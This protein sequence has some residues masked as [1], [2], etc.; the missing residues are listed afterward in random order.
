MLNITVY[1]THSLVSDELTLKGKNVVVIDALRA[2]STIT[3]ALVNGAK[4]VI[5]TENAA[6]AVRVA[7]GSGNSMLCGERGGRIIEGF[8]LGNSPLEYTAETIKDKSLVFSTTNG[9]LSLAKA[10]YSK[11]CIIASFLNMTAV[12]D[13]LRELNEDFVIICSGK[14]NNFCLEDAVCAGVIIRK[15]TDK[16]EENYSVSDPENACIKLAKEYAYEKGRISPHKILD[17][18]KI[19]EHGKYLIELGFE[20]DLA[21]CS[22][23]DSLQS[24]PI[25]KSGIIKLKEQFEG[26]SNQKKQMKKLSLTTD[27]EEVSTKDVA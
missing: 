4:E 10:K 15:L 20:N 3:T 6:T 22:A 13:Y 19:S 8:N 25:L 18:M 26:E 27:K 1:L 11:N 9:T 17:M 23:L 5:P 24:I 14:L 12:V 7:K 21:A 16:Q 2:T